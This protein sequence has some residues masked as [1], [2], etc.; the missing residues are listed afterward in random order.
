VLEEAACEN[1]REESK[2]V[3]A[4]TNPHS[5]GVWRVNGVVADVPGFRDAFR[6]KASQP[7]ARETPCRAG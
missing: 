2:R 1:E 5:P 6:C 3:N 4:V 7:V